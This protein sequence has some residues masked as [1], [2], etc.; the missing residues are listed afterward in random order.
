M[1]KILI[2]TLIIGVI[3]LI[4]GALLSVIS[5]LCD[6]GEENECLADI[7]DALPGANC[8]ACGFAG[9]DSYAEAVEKGDAEPNLCAPGGNDTAQKLSEILGV[10]ITPVSLIAK[11]LCNGCKENVDTKFNYGGEKSCRS[12]AM[13]GGGPSACSYGCIGYGDCVNVCKFNALSIVDGVAVVNSDLC[14]GCGA[15]AK[16]CPKGIISIREKVNTANVLC[17]SKEKGAKAKKICKT[18][19][20]GCSLCKK[21]CESDAIEIKDFLAF[22]NPEKCTACGKCAQKCPQKAI[23]I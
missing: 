13:L 7:R 17:S 6:K 23:E 18:A 4:A 2:A 1:E 21:V 20:I 22:I 14:T 9:C 16:I 12:A 19:C 10:E 8:G 3:G 5:T 15:C 11:V